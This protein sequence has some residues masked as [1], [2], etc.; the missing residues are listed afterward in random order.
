[1]RD[2]INYIVSEMTKKEILLRSLCSILF[3]M[4]YIVFSK[5]DRYL[6][7]I[8]RVLGTSFDISIINHDVRNLLDSNVST[9]TSQMVPERFLHRSNN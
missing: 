1:M 8:L 7:S 9:T 6:Q 5:Y 4:L 3:S 2:Y